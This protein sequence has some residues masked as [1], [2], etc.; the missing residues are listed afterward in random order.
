MASLRQALLSVLGQAWPIK[1]P[2]HR[3]IVRTDKRPQTTPR[4][5]TT[6]TY[7][8]STHTHTQ[9]ASLFRGSLSPFALTVGS[10]RVG[11]VGGCPT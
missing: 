6:T 7:V 3:F 5:S 8:V 4:E 10:W 9:L 11:P 1:L 2:K